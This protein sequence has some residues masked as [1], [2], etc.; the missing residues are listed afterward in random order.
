MIVKQKSNRGVIQNCICI[1]A[2]VIPLRQ[3]KYDLLS[4]VVKSCLKMQ[5]GNASLE[6]FFW[7]QEYVEKWKN[8]FG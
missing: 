8:E 4:K 6:R 3:K 1:M 2:F 7:Q 5:N